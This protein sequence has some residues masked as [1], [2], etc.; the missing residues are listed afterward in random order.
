M[1]YNKQILY[2]VIIPLV[3]HYCF[4]SCS[5]DIGAKH[6]M[7]QSEE[8]MEDDPESAF[9]L[10]DS[11]LRS[12]SVS[13][14]YALMKLALIRAEAMNKTFRMMDTLSVIDEV[15]EYFRD[16]GTG[17]ERMRA[18]YMQGCVYRDRNNSTKAIRCFNE[19]LSSVDSTDTDYDEQLACRIYAQKAG[20]LS[21]ERSVQP[22]IE[23]WDNA[24]RLAWKI[25]DTVGV[26]NYLSYKCTPYYING[27][28]D[29]VLAISDAAY[30]LALAFGDK[31]YI[32]ETLGDKILYLIES[33]DFAKAGHLINYYEKY[34]SIIDSSG[35]VTRGRELYYGYKGKYFEGINE[36]DSAIMCY[37]QLLRYGS[38][39]DNKELACRQLV[40]FYTK[41]GISDSVTKYAN[42][43]VQV[44]DSSWRI[45]QTEDLNRMQ[46]I[47]N[48]D[49][50]RQ[51]AMERQKE[52]MRYR[53]MFFVGI[54][55]S[56]FLIYL[57][58]VYLN[59]QRR[60]SR[61]VMA[62]LN[63]EYSEVLIKYVKLEKDMDMLRKDSELYAQEKQ[64]ELDKLR[65]MLTNFDFRD[66][67][68]ESLNN[69]NGVFD[70]P[71]VI[72]MH[73]RA[74]KC[75]LPTDV[76]WNNLI[77]FIQT[78]LPNFWN[79]INGLGYNLTDKEKLVAMLVKLR[80]LPS[81]IT[82]LLNLSSQRVS[83][84][85]SSINKKLFKQSGTKSL[86]FN[87]RGIN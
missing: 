68:V 17:T 36:M 64:K 42:L 38:L 2:P 82:V 79:T 26:I 61:M 55:A 77:I 66:S 12:G 80:F 8:I 19:A 48:V 39:L 76:E 63:K 15:A 84:M 22:A 21:I 52:A 58:V 81:E 30:K 13:T 5:D 35:S 78:Q 57:L 83:N 85:R 31:E 28:Q 72:Q 33:N 3:F 27:M 41:L 11:L 56:T 24:I 37:R 53:V 10:V 4:S 29:S 87:L 9:L 70:S 32:A 47:Y 73:R 18:L 44:N 51:M 1:R 74:A 60:K 20:L 45:R 23:A 49:E 75:T 69:V 16:K 40:S 43:Y 50:S 34:S 54:S 71:V 25:K 6:I 59:R 67:D 86:D 65:G 7:S 14:K 62:N 46:I